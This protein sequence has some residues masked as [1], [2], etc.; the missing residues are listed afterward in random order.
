MRRTL[1]R[2]NSIAFPR[3]LRDAIPAV[4]DGRILELDSINGQASNTPLF[5]PVVELKLI[6]KETGKLTDSFVLLMRLQPEAARQLSATLSE[7]AE[8][9]ENWGGP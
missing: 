2:R 8:R 9:A 3:E 7:L 4:H 6:V 1:A 5:G